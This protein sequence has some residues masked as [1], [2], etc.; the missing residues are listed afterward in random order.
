VS[1]FG[2]PLNKNESTSLVVRVQFVDGTRSEHPLINGKHIANYQ[3][4]IDVP[5]SKFA[6]DASGKQVRYL[7]VPIDSSKEVKS[8]ELAK[9]DDFSTPLVFAVTVESAGSE[10]H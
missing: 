1:T 5:E 4:R 10:S 6:L 7:R 3:E 9:G 2:F 8:I